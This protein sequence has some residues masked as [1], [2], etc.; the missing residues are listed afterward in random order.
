[1]K[2]G[3][4][5]G[6]T[7]VDRELE[8]LVYFGDLPHPTCPRSGTRASRTWTPKQWTVSIPSLP[9]R[10]H[11]GIAGNERVDELARRAVLDKKTAADYDRF[12]LSH[13]KN[14]IRAARLEEWQQRYA[15][16]M[17]Q[18]LTGHGGFA[19]YLYRFKLRDSPYCACDPSKIQDVLYVLEVCDMFVS[20]RRWKR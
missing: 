1:M 15:E 5:M 6:D 11:I 12:P 8:R 13:V 17:A 16:G 20:V 4:D 10:A 14:M 2:R 7:F 18:I 19:L 3:K 9:W